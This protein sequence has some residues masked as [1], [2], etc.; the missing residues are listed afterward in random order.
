MK[1]QTLRLSL[2]LLLVA[3]ITAGILGVINYFTAPI[4]A[5]RNLEST[6]ESYAA[7]LPADSYEDVEYT[8][9][10]PT[11]TKICKAADGSGWVFETSFSGAQ[12]MINRVIGVSSEYK[13]TGISII[14]HS[15]TSGLGA[16]A[17]EQSEKGEA[18]RN[19]FIGVDETAAL[20]KNGGDIVQISGA[21]I[22]SNAITTE[23]DLCITVAKTLG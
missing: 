5:Q 23:V 14:S 20:Q 13:C 2:I 21:T 12:G 16:V 17:A 18:F 10:D 4:I 22:T 8:G 3:A 11:I 9:D 6:M 1:N 7:V 15:E 19:Q